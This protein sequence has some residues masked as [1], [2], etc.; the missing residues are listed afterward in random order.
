MKQKVVTAVSVA[1]LAGISVIGVGFFAEPLAKTE[2]KP[3]AAVSLSTDVVKETVVVT[4]V[5]AVIAP[6]EA[7]SISL[8]Q[9]TESTGRELKTPVSSSR[10]SKKDIFYMMLNSIDYYDKVSG[11]I[12]VHY[13]NIDF[14]ETVTFQCALSDTAAYAH[15]TQY[16][17][18]QPAAAS[19]AE[20]AEQMKSAKTAVL[21]D[22]E[23]SCTGEQLYYV[24]H[25]RS[26]YRQEQ[27]YNITTLEQAG[28][29]PDEERHFTTDDGFPA[30]SYRANPTN[31]PSASICIF[32]QEM[33]FGY[34]TDTDLWEIK[35]VEKL[36][37]RTCYH[38]TGVTEESYGKKLG[39][40]SFE[41]FVDTD[42]GVLL[43]YVGYDTNG[44]ISGYLY[45]E[46]MQFE[47]KAEAVKAASI[48][49]SYQNE[50]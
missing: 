42:T 10:V 8:E 43:K 7:D 39:V 21:R 44:N 27:S 45:S 46:N 9:T 50:G 33:T 48:P 12:Y 13:G 28:S 37:G 36:N 47:E 14:Y 4:E 22:V 25:S 23:T 6:E 49:R 16:E 17:C 38:I 40:E 41:F 31:I 20:C 24:D 18:N 29:I 5:S 3:Q 2:E 34:L 15:E 30:Y 1:A 19:A 35:G 32:P 26:A 11:T